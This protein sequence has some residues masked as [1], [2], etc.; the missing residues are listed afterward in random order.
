MESKQKETFIQ[1]TTY[2]VLAYATSWT[3]WFPLY[4][5]IF[6]IPNLPILPYQHGLGGLGP[7][8]ASILTTWIYFRKDGL[9]QLLQKSFQLKP[10]LYLL[11]AAFAPFLLVIISALIDANLNNSPF[12]IEKLL[13]VKEFPNFN[14]ATFFFY[15]L[16]FF[17]FGEEVGWRGFALPRF[18]NR[19]NALV[20]AIL[21]TAFWAIW[22]WPLFFY[23]TGYTSMGLGGIVGWVLSLLTGSILFTWLFNST[24]GSIFICAIFHSTVDVAFTADIAQGNVANYLGAMITIW[25]ILT[26]LVFKPRNLANFQRQQ[27]VDS[28]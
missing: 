5:H 18:Q 15:N 14:L 23:R 27:T 28:Y 16:V 20:A 11:I 12:Q 4:G 24:K 19:N 10:I 25:G 8:F 2:F 7:M 17:G 13:T 3:I 26:I 9:K 6:G 1:L 21:L 22:H